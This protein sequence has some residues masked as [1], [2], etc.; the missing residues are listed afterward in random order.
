MLLQKI[1]AFLKA[2]RI[3]YDLFSLS[4]ETITL[5]SVSEF[6]FDLASHLLLIFAH[7]DSD[8]SYFIYVTRTL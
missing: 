3:L 7:H 6:V 1:S 4:Q 8:F 5:V 2:N